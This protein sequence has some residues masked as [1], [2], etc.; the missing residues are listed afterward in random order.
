[1]I[2]SPMQCGLI[3]CVDHWLLCCASDWQPLSEAHSINHKL[4]ALEI[5]DSVKTSISRRFNKPPTSNLFLLAEYRSVHLTEVQ[6]HCHNYEGRLY[7]VCTK[8]TSSWWDVSQ[9]SST[10][11][12]LFYRWSKSSVYT[13]CFYSVN[14]TYDSILVARKNQMN[15][16]KSKMSRL[17]S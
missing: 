4:I 2:N 15:K 13:F 5:I 14:H 10:V 11:E 8:L 16:N 9:A 6:P 3:V 1:M 12:Q 17:E 7:R